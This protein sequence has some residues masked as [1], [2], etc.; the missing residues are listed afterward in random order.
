MNHI[1]NRFFN[2][3]RKMTY[4]GMAH[5][6]LI[7]SVTY[8][9]G[10]SQSGFGTIDRVKTVS[11]EYSSGILGNLSERD[12]QLL[13]NQ[14]LI[15]RNLGV[16]LISDSAKLHN[17]EKVVIYQQLN[18]PRFTDTGTVAGSVITTTKAMSADLYRGLYVWQ[19]TNLY[20]IVSNTATAIT[21]TGTPSSGS[22]LI[23]GYTAWYPVFKNIA[24]QVGDSQPFYQVICSNIPMIDK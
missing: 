6:L 19:G 12:A 4:S 14:G 22:F 13:E 17:K 23:S 20:P 16:W 1:T 8:T 5:T 15:N 18:N 2:E 24:P 21:V 10:T 11:R 3:F 9:G 7:E